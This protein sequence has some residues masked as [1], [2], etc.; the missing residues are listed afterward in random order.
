MTVPPPPN[1]LG[2]RDIEYSWIASHIPEGPGEALDFGAGQGHMGL[3]AAMK[4]FNVT[5]IDLIP[6]TWFYYHDKLA[7]TK[8]DILDSDFPDGH[9]DLV[10]NCSVVEHIGLAGRYK[11]KEDN[12]HGNYRRLH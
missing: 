5:A 4:G 10:I 6:I 12:E 8:G 11:A 3:I 9:F 7:F 1:L 2:D